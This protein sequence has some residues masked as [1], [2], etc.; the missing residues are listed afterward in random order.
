MKAIG[1]TKKARIVSRALYDGNPHS[2]YRYLYENCAFEECERTCAVNWAA[3]STL[4]SEEAK[5]DLEATIISHQAQV[6]EKLGHMQEAIEVCEKGINIRLGE[7][8]RKQVLIA[9]SYCNL[10]IIYSSSNNFTKALECFKQSRK[11]WADYFDGKGETRAYA[12]P[13]QVSEARCMVGLNKLDQAEEM[14]DS[15]VSQV[16]SERPLNFGTLA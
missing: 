2:L 16:K 13:M 15:M 3:V 14:L 12:A 7:T 10:G 8:P 1:S 4:T 9:Y 11:W 6:L 5:I